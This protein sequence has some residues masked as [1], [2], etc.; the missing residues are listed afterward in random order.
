[1]VEKEDPVTRKRSSDEDHEDVF[2]AAAGM[3]V[4]K[5]ETPDESD[6]KEAIISKTNK[7]IESVAGLATELLNSKEFQDTPETSDEEDQ[8]FID[9]YERDIRPR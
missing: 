5:P 2:L 6:I 9:D 4:D 3:T 8:K 1:L 7:T